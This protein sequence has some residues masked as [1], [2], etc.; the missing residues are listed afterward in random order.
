M[1][2]DDF[3]A[4]ATNQS[5]GA[6]SIPS[7]ESF[8]T[9][10]IA[11]REKITLSSGIVS[12]AS[13]TSNSSFAFTRGFTITS[14]IVSS[15]GFHN[16]NTFSQNSSLSIPSVQYVL[17]EKSIDSPSLLSSIGITLLPIDSSESLPSSTISNVAYISFSGNGI[18]SLE[19]LGSHTFNS[20]SFIEQSTSISSNE[21]VN[22]NHTLSLE[23]SLYPSSI[24]PTVALQNDN[25]FGSLVGIVVTSGIPTGFSSPTNSTLA[26]LGTLQNIL[27][28]SGITSREFFGRR[29]TFLPPP[30]SYLRNGFIYGYTAI[31]N[32]IFVTLE[33]ENI[34]DTI[35]RIPRKIENVQS[36]SES[37]NG[38][39]ESKHIL[40]SNIDVVYSIE[41]EIVQEQTV[42]ARQ[43][44]YFL[45]SYI[46][47]KN[48]IT[49][50]IYVD[51]NNIYFHRR[52]GKIN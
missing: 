44:K 19:S 50:N 20:I 29:I 17:A 26:P 37:I 2:A 34:L 33:R 40:D 3:K 52:D 10:T 43:T 11:L 27:V 12:L 18:S 41:G 30:P 28:G 22:N 15:E 32:N 45:E 49:S 38:Y 16:D 7:E 21:F 4:Q 36:K 23:N 25:Y 14:G 6:T 51:E 47:Q 31:V 8:G 42:I 39:I 46:K 35:T 48:K 13:F 24:G 9:A 5:I 1:S